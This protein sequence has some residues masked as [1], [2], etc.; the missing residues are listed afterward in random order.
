[1]RL[2]GWGGLCGFGAVA[3]RTIGV[4]LAIFKAFGDSG[5]TNVAPTGLMIVCFPFLQRCR[6]YG[7]EEI[8][9]GFKV[10]V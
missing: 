4:N 3:N 10:S 5:S 6:P 2:F 8:F 9:E 7:T 1:M